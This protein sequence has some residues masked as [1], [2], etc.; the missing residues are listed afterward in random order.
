M[1]QDMLDQPLTAKLHHCWNTITLE[2]VQRRKTFQIVGMTQNIQKNIQDVLTR[3]SNTWFFYAKAVED[4]TDL[5]C[6]KGLTE[7]VQN[8]GFGLGLPLSLTDRLSQDSLSTFIYAF[9]CLELCLE[10]FLGI[11]LP[12]SIFPHEVHC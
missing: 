9:I 7:F 11:C 3:N 12:P 1:H 4:I 8:H 10:S 5:F 6:T 2:V